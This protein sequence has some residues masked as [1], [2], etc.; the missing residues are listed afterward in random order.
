MHVAFPVL[1]HTLAKQPSSYTHTH[2]HTHTHIDTHHFCHACS[3][4]TSIQ[5]LTPSTVLAMQ[6]KHCRM[7]H[8][9]QLVPHQSSATP[10]QRILLLCPSWST[11]NKTFFYQRCIPVVDIECDFALYSSRHFKGSVLFFQ[12]Q[13]LSLP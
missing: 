10:R 5:S 1:C 6:M 12:G 8:L 2:T 3:P 9:S 13:D 11:A 4:T 7:L